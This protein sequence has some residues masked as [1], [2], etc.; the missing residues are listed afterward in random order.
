MFGLP[1]LMSTISAS[2][3]A[4][5]PTIEVYGPIGLRQM[6]RTNLNLARSQLQFSY[7][8]HELHHDIEPGDYDGMVC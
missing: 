3:T 1:G 8:V 6:L 4:D 5:G 7:V 2:F